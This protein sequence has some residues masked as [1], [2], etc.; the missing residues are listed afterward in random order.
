MNGVPTSEK[1]YSI[2]RVNEFDFELKQKCLDKFENKCA[3]CSA[4]KHLEIDHVIPLREGGLNVL[5]NLQVLCYS[6]H[7]EKTKEDQKRINEL[8]KFVEAYPDARAAFSVSRKVRQLLKLMAAYNDTS[9]SKL[10][11]KIVYGKRFKRIPKNEMP[12]WA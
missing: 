7:L 2:R 6:C 12:K 3:G 5:E 1:E 4:T 9:M 11:E 10:L 8:P